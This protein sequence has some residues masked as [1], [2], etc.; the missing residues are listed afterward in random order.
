MQ[1]LQSVLT[2]LIM[3]VVIAVSHSAVPTAHDTP[4]V[5][6]TTL[7]S[8]SVK[9]RVDDGNGH[10][11]GT[12][13][14]IDV[15]QSPHSPTG[16]EALILTCGHIFRESQGQG[17]VEAHLFSDNS[18]VRVYG[19]CI[20]Y[21]LEIDLALVAI[22]PP[23]PVRAAPIAPEGYQIQSFQQVWSV[24]CDHGGHPTIRTHQIM[25]VDR[26]S[27]PR[28]NRVP[29]HYV[30]VSG[31][32][33][34][35]RSGG[36]LFSAN[37][38]LIGVCNTACPTVNDGHFVPPHMIRHVLDTLHLSF[39]YQNPSLGEPPRQTP[40][41][42]ELAALS[43]LAPLVPLEP[44]P[45]A[46]SMVMATPAPMFAESQVDVGQGR[47]NWEGVEHRTQDGAEAIVI[48]RS[49][50]NPEIPSD[51]IA[52]NRA[53][54][55]FLDALVNSPTQPARTMG[56]PTPVL[57]ESQGGMSREEQATLEEI[58]RRKQ[59]G[60]EVIVVIR[61]TGNHEI[62]SDVIVMNGASDR[63]LDAVVNNPAQSASPSYNPI[64]FSSHD[65][66]ARTASRLPVSFPVRH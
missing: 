34:S 66:P 35:G 65:A 5:A 4:A 20:F 54:E 51:V 30:Q 45:T 7:I 63:F 42:M 64:I 3:T 48:I 29:F 21:D 55:R 50:R 37:G 60:A 17:Y 49:P 18:T 1:R 53:S 61:S 11:W 14:I 39:V 12:G 28:E 33:V 40:P 19:R 41:P 27:T 25:S 59:D 9:L 8:S 62:P 26:I 15:R 24:G 23:V 10:S 16:Q 6:L 44:I 52:M 38:Y 13:T 46:P 47:L 31:A 57:A 58:T 36:G 56:I 32:P 43:P 2:P 22:A